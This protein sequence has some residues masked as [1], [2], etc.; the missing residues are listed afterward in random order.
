MSVFKSFAF[1]CCEASTLE[2]LDVVWA[3]M[4]VRFGMLKG[5]FHVD[6]CEFRAASTFVSVRL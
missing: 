5:Y 1:R 6:G 3:S 2:H 4:L